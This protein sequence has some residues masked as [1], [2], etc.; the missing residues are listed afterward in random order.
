[1]IMI[2][3]MY[4]YRNSLKNNFFSQNQIK[5]FMLNFNLFSMWE[6]FYI[7]VNNNCMN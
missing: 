5:N 2:K 3:Y 7:W 4:Q 6:Y 1:M